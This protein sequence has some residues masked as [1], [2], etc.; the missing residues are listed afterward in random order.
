M[1]VSI[2]ESDAEYD[3]DTSVK[4]NSSS[5]PYRMNVAFTKRNWMHWPLKL[6]Y[7]KKKRISQE[8]SSTHYHY[9]FNSNSHQQ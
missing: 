1:E 6:H 2:A 8:P 3:D 5:W 4:C 9:N 7:K